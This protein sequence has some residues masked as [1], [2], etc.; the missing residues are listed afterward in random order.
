MD[1]LKAN[2]FQYTRLLL[3]ANFYFS[4]AILVFGSAVSLS[5]SYTLF[6]FNADIYGEL[7]NNLRIMMVYLAFTELLIFGYC[8]IT[9]QNQYYLIVGMFLL[10]MIPGLAFYGQVNNVEID[11]NLDIFFFYTGVS[12][13]LWGAMTKIKIKK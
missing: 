13:F 10:T 4:M 12:H 3:E 5:S 7:A 6:E 1:A 2:T 8:F 11:P 9:Q